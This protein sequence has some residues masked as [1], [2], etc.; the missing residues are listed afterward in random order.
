ML[1]HSD[2]PCTSVAQRTKHTQTHTDYNIKGQ[3]PM[4]QWTWT[5]IKSTIATTVRLI[6][7][8]AIASNTR[9]WSQWAQ[10]CTCT[11]TDRLTQ[12]YDDYVILLPRSYL[13]QKDAAA[14]FSFNCLATPKS[15]NLIVRSRVSSTLSGFKSLWMVCSSW[16]LW[17]AWQIW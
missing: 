3:T 10:A 8:A 13:P 17:T 16:Q 9:I 1:L 2:V 4:E 12:W 6:A 11:L 5:T 7:C 14:E 15:H